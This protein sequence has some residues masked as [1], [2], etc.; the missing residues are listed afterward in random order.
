MNNKGS[1]M[2][3]QKRKEFS[4]TVGIYFRDLLDSMSNC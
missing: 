1:V 2:K 4:E 3:G